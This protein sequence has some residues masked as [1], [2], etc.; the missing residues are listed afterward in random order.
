MA[1]K[2]RVV[3][4]DDDDIFAALLTA[5]LA[6]EYD[7]AVGRSGREGLELLRG[8]ADLL[9]TDIG[10][11]D[12]DGIELLGLLDKDPRFGA[13]PVIIVTATHFNQR[14]VS[15]VKRFRQVREVI[16]KPCR[17]EQILVSM[18]KVLQR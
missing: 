3:I 17:V 10:M 5:S 7:V 14:P 1:Q 13:I 6:P 2:P 11:A 16:C 18:R 12:I 4:L 8:G 15:E 9:I